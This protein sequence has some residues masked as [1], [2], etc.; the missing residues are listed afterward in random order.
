MDAPR[1]FNP[2]RIAAASPAP[3]IEGDNREETDA[4][5]IDVMPTREGADIVTLDELGEG[6]HIST[7]LEE[8]NDDD[9]GADGDGGAGT[10][11]NA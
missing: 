7:D 10:D 3:V 5:D 6:E 9:G 11:D 8:G 2:T 1:S 4:E